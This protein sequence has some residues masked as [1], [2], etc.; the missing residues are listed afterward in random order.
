MISILLTIKDHYRNASSTQIIVTMLQFSTLCF[1]LN[2]ICTGEL[3]STLS[4]IYSYPGSLSVLT[5]LCI[6]GFSQ[7]WVF[8]YT[9]INYPMVVLLTLISSRPCLKYIRQQLIGEPS[10]WRMYNGIMGVGVVMFMI[11]LT[12]LYG[13]IHQRKT[14]K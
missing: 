2:L 11:S 13:K 4:L 10:E 14:G 7:Y 6:L 9:L 1:G 5:Q 3:L 12:K 8:S